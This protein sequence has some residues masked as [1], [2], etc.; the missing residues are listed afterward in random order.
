MAKSHN[1]VLLCNDS[2]KSWSRFL[3]CHAL[4][5]RA[6]QAYP[7]K[8]ELVLPE[9]AMNLA[10]SDTFPDTASGLTESLAPIKAHPQPLW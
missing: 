7:G 4:L 5:S 1:L 3:F 2:A 6:A 9:L 8:A 10:K